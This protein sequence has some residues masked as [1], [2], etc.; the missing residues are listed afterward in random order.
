MEKQFI[1]CKPK[2]F[3]EFIIKHPSVQIT[4]G[5]SLVAINGGKL[6]RFE[7]VDINEQKIYYNYI[8]PMADFEFGINNNVEQWLCETAEQEL[9]ILF[10][11]GFKNENRL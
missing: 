9:S 4:M 6:F 5:E 11:G 8:V 2:T 10:N 3:M 7:A 1:V